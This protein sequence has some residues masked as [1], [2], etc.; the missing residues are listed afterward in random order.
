MT[1]MPFFT[2]TLLR[3]YLYNIFIYK[4][5]YGKRK[6]WEKENMGVEG[7]TKKKKKRNYEVVLIVRASS[8][9]SEDGP[10]TNK[11]K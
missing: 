6:S 3:L 4:Q 7:R 5:L 9:R 2:K 8:C 10:E 1:D 11:Q